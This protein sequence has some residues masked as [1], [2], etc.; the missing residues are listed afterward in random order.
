M[1]GKVP[2]ASTVD[3]KSAQGLTLESMFLLGGCIEDVNASVRG[4]AH[5][6]TVPLV[7]LA[8][9]DSLTGLS[10][11]GPISS[12]EDA[13][14]KIDASKLTENA[15][16][17]VLMR[18]NMALRMKL[19]ELQGRLKTDDSNEQ[20]SNGAKQNLTDASP[21][22]VVSPGSLSVEM[23]SVDRINASLYDELREKDASFAALQSRAKQLEAQYKIAVV[24]RRTL[25]REK[26]V[27]VAA[28]ERNLVELRDKIR[29]SEEKSSAE[30]LNL[31][32]K[33]LE[34]RELHSEDVRQLRQEL[35]EKEE[36]VQR[37][38]SRQGQVT[39]MEGRNS[40][41]SIIIPSQSG[42]STQIVF[43]DS[44][45][46]SGN[47]EG[48]QGQSLGDVTPLLREL[49]AD[50]SRRL[51]LSSTR[52]DEAELQ[53]AQY[54]EG[55]ELELALLRGELLSFQVRAD[56][57]WHK[58]KKEIETRLR[59]DMEQEHD[60]LQTTL[61]DMKRILEAQKEENS[62]LLGVIADQKD[63][64]KKWGRVKEK[65]KEKHERY[66]ST[67]TSHEG[68]V[69][70]MRESLL[71][72]ES[73]ILGLSEKLRNLSKQAHQ[74]ENAAAQSEEKEAEA[75]RGWQE[76]KQALEAKVHQYENACV[77]LESALKSAESD[78]Q[79][80]ALFR[81]FE[82]SS[83]GLTGMHRM[84]QTV[85]ALRSE[86]EKDR[87][88]FKQLIQL[89]N[90]E[91]EEEIEKRKNAEKRRDI[92]VGRLELVAQ[93]TTSR[94]KEKTEQ[95]DAKDIQVA[96]LEKQIRKLS[97]F[98]AEEFDEQLLLKDQKIA[99]LE[100]LYGEEHGAAAELRQELVKVQ[101]SNM[102]SAEAVRQMHEEQVHALNQQ[103][104]SLQT[105]ID[106]LDGALRT[107]IQ[108]NSQLQEKLSACEQEIAQKS[109]SLSSTQA[110]MEQN[111]KDLRR[112]L[113]ET[114]GRA[115]AEKERWS[116]K[117]EK[118]K[119]A[120][121]EMKKNYQEQLSELR[122]EHEKAASAARASTEESI[123]LLKKT[124]EEKDQQLAAM[125]PPVSLVLPPRQE[126]DTSPLTVAPAAGA[127]AAVVPSGPALP[128]YILKDVKV[129]TSTV[130]KHESMTP[131][132]LFAGL[133]F[134]L[135]ILPAATHPEFTSEVIR[136][137]NKLIQPLT[138]SQM[139]PDLISVS[140][141]TISFYTTAPGAFMANI[142]SDIC[143]AR[144][145]VDLA[146]LAEY[147]RNAQPSLMGP[148]FMV[149]GKTLCPAA[150]LKEADISS[151]TAA[152]V[153]ETAVESAATGANVTPAPAAPVPAAVP[154]PVATPPAPA[155]V[156]ASPLNDR[157]RAAMERLLTSKLK[158]V[159]AVKTTPLTAGSGHTYFQLRIGD[160]NA[161]AKYESSIQS[162]VSKV[163]AAL[164]A[165]NL[166]PEFQ[167]ADTFW[168]RLLRSAEKKKTSPNDTVLLELEIRIK[169]LILWKKEVQ[170]EDQP[171]F[172]IGGKSFCMP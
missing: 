107:K 134:T 55:K 103:C 12:D 114:E 8:A 20:V 122:A 29:I 90:I 141:F 167:Q 126:T 57:L 54:R 138:P 87:L 85:K 123:K 117:V 70:K 165:S 31:T 34:E 45:S 26:E 60:Q 140:T 161:E 62:Q 118:L 170:K 154:A 49:E 11:I 61:L 10:P 97:T 78:T 56:E 156:P 28:M 166:P 149:A 7:G 32:K 110:E 25:E 116:K 72:K 1:T 4:S 50:F 38:E 76:E 14:N 48:Q 37:M 158:D 22:A 66:E 131:E 92:D 98:D 79:K 59:V 18:E 121:V 83:K 75:R 23:E 13:F 6:T 99:H 69:Q 81:K 137:T 143:I 101:E 63:K 145:M 89:A 146:D 109:S 96:A 115:D 130:L 112:R 82:A 168:M 95:L 44:P 139:N 91:R 129:I 17:D 2:V 86:R 169:D 120:N 74:W 64:M 153:T 73:A 46:A 77:E 16:Y 106:E 80:A 9:S 150:L 136:D 27:S 124:L 135:S 15:Y 68:E 172:M 157:D 152:A 58:K 43:V 125:T 113:E 108:D 30:A 51:M 164:S 21:K 128:A 159:R 42:S 84:F 104:K 35:S 142:S 155:A 132:G 52:A 133:Y 47:G 53:F 5:L 119:Q 94:L 162:N 105:Q 39:R 171:L 93:Q 88:E 40:N 160:K 71:S 3:G 67:I 163:M 24:A 41:G 36:Y 100:K 19:G 65:L 144:F 33:L 111:L 148:L 147:K 102:T 151:A 127:D